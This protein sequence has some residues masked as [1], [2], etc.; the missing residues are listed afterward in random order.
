MLLFG[1][2][3]GIVVG[4]AL[5][6]HVKAPRSFFCMLQGA[7]CLVAITTLWAL[8]PITSELVRGV[9]WIS[10]RRAIVILLAIGSIIVPPSILLGLSFPITQKAVQNDAALI[11]RRVGFVQFANILG[12]AAGSMITGLV[13][14]Q[15]IGTTGSI[16]LLLG[17]GLAFTCVALIESKGTGGRWR[18]SSLAVP[19][20]LLLLLVSFPT[21]LQFYAAVHLVDAKKRSSQKTAPAFLYSLLIHRP[22]QSFM[23]RATRKVPSHSEPVTWFSVCSDR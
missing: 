6:S 21:N 7:I 4:S 23:W 12:N 8:V 11:G 5:V 17:T 16:R 2:A 22:T 18:A 20:A 14:L 19:V 9:D 1:D 13:L 15:Y 3:I 10:A